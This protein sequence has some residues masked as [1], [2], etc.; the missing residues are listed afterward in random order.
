MKV[1]KAAICLVLTALILIS[2]CFSAATAPAL[3]GADAPSAPAKKYA[4]VD[5]GCNAYLCGE[6][7]ESAALFLIPIARLPPLSPCRYQKTADSRVTL[8]STIYLPC[9]MLQYPDFYT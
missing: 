2:P 9:I 5:L 8:Q 3:A 6:P 4:Y 7:N 1:L